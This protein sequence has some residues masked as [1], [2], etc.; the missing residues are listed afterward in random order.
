M[1]YDGQ[2]DELADHMLGMF[3]TLTEWHLLIS[4]FYDV[5]A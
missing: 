5:A 2:N 4:A 3:N 1:R